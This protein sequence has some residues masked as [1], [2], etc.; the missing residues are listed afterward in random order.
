MAGQR[1]IVQVVRT[2]HSA[3]GFAS[4]LNR[5]KQ[6]GDENADD[7]NDDEKFDEGKAGSERSAREPGHVHKPPEEKTG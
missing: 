1:Q 7:G 4:R 6:H 5:G 2:L 3:G